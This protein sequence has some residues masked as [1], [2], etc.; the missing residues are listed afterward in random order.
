MHVIIVNFKIPCQFLFGTHNHKK[1]KKNTRGGLRYMQFILIALSMHFSQLAFTQTDLDAL[2]MN[3]NQFCNGFVY[4]NSSWDNYWEGNRKRI[5]ENLGTVSTNSLTYMANYGIKDKLNIMVGAPYIRTKAT[6]GT[7]QGVSGIQDFSLFVKWRMVNKKIGKQK[8]SIFAIAGFTS[9]LQN[10]VIDYLPLSIGLGSKTFITRL[11][12]DYQWRKWTITASSSH[13]RRSNV[14]LDRESYYTTELHLTNQVAMPDALQSQLRLG[15]R[16]RYFI[17]EGLLSN[18][19]TLGG[20]DITRNNMPFPS[21]RMNGTTAGISLKYTI[22]SYTNLSLLG[23]A[24]YT[25]QGRNIGQSSMFSGGI[26]YA[27]YVK[28]KGQKADKKTK[29]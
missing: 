24:Q 29:N 8:F 21:N 16:G 18:W 6:A 2:M 1:M 4:S 17:A 26:F 28:K 3:K 5:N 25:V 27:F 20:F 15:Y 9:P 19:T 11:M 22:K 14:S 23:N 7:L 13:H 10:Y 12:A